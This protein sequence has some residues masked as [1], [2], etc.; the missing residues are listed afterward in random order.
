MHVNKSPH[1]VRKHALLGAQLHWAAHAKG[2]LLAEVMAVKT[3][4][5]TNLLYCL[6][7]FSR[8]GCATA[9][10]NTGCTQLAI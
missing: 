8:N 1:T 3:Q 5:Q 9:L 4:L 10:R 2:L 6:L 7:I